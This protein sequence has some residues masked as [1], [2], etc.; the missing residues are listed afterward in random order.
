MSA[1]ANPITPERF[2]TA[3]ED[4]SISSLY[5]KAAEITNSITH[6]QLSNEQLKPFADGGDVD[7]A[8]ALRENE[9]VMERMRERIELLRTEVE[10]R[11]NLWME[12]K[13]NV[14]D[15][16]PAL[17][18]VVA[19]GS[20]IT[21]VQQGTNDAAHDDGTASRSGSLTDDERARQM[22]HQLGEDD[23]GGLH[24]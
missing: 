3:L 15:A 14:E 13:R 12:A 8:E 16:N 19:D 20:I 17:D 5:A 6:L 18:G 24:L 4:L 9:D 22:Q 10:R 7:C 11:G 2:A 1:T 21:A 23:D